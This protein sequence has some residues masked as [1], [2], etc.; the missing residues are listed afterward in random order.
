MPLRIAYGM[1]QHAPETS[2]RKGPQK[3]SQ[4]WLIV[5]NTHDLLTRFPEPLSPCCCSWLNNCAYLQTSAIGPY[6]AFVVGINSYKK[7]P[8]LSKCVNDAKDMAALLARK[9]YAVTQLLNPTYKELH[10]KFNSFLESLSS[11][12]N[13]VVF[14]SGHGME[15]KG[16][17]YLMPKD[18]DPL[19]KGWCHRQCHH[20][21]SAQVPLCVCVGFTWN[22]MKAKQSF[23][24][25]VV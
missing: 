17:N 7:L 23:P 21:C 6:A 4:K 10:V 25:H 14:F 18:A 3:F 22:A 1:F 16:E 19:P 24:L 20:T 13:V 11:D 8:R 12:C 15:E 5:C 2:A 9:G